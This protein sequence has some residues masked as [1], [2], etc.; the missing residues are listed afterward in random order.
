MFIRWLVVL[1]MCPIAL[2]PS[3][4]PARCSIKINKAQ[5]ALYLFAN[6][7]LVKQYPVATGKNDADKGGVGDMA[8]PEGTFTIVQ[9]EDASKWDHVYPEA[10]HVGAVLCYG[11]HFMRLSTLKSETFSGRGPWEG[12]GIHGTSVENIQAADGSYWVSGPRSIGTSSSE[13]C[14]RLQNID[15]ADL[16]ASLRRL[17]GNTSPMGVPV[18]IVDGVKRN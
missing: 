15:L 5:H 4:E 9:I 18:T 10:A 6:G 1:L 17:R 8:T 7:A 14:I 3:Q 12:I 2:F 13:G 16:M 11:P